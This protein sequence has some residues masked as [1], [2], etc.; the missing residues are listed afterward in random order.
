MSECDTPNTWT[1]TLAN[2]VALTI[3]A[4]AQTFLNGSTDAYSG[5]A[6]ASAHTAR[7]ILPLAPGTNGLMIT[8]DA[9]ASV[10]LSHYDQ[11]L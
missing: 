3:D 9:S 1:G 4:G 8:T 6:Y 5:L 11:W 7:G 2:G 10:S